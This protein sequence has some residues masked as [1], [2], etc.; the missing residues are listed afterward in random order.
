M[1]TEMDALRLSNGAAI[2]IILGL[3]SGTRAGD[4]EALTFERHVRP[5]LKAYCLDCHGSGTELKGKL[6]LRLARTARKGGKQGPALVPGKPEESLLL[7]RIREG[8]M[9]PGEKRVPPAQVAVIEGW[10]AQGARTLRDEPQSLPPGIDITLEERAFW[11]FQPNRQTGPPS[12]APGDRARVRTPIDVFL[13]DALRRRGSSFA[14]EADRLTLLCRAAFDLTGLPPDDDL[15]EA[16]LA[17]RRPDSYE[18]AI[19]RLLDSPHYGE[20]WARYWLDVA[21][22]ADSD[23]DGNEDTP[24]PYAYRYRDYVV[25][26]FNSDKPLDRFIIEQLAGDELVPRPWANL[27]PEQ[28]ETLAATGYLRMVADPTSSGG[29]DQAMASNQ[30]VADTLKVVGSSLLGLTVGCAQ[31]HDHRY[32]PIPQSDYYRLRAVFEPALDPS[33]WR[34]PSQRLVS[35]YADADRAIAAAVEAEAQKLEK[36]LEPKVARYM[37]EALEKE[38]MKFPVDVRDKLRDAYRTPEPKR[39]GEQRKLLASHPSVNLTEGVLYQYNQAAADDLKKERAKIAAVRARK[40]VEEFVS[41]LDEVPGVLPE[42][43]IFHRGD[44]RQ[45]TR[46]VAPGD[47][48]IAAPPGAPFQIG[49]KDA[50]VPTSGRRLAY[51]R[52][53]VDGRHPLVGRVLVNRIWMHHFGRGLVETPGDLGAL[54]IRPTHPDLL[55]WL[56]SELMRQNWSLKRMHRLIMT[57]T[58]YRLSS[59]RESAG[60]DADDAWYGRFPVRRLDAEVLRDRVL[61]ASGRLDPRLYGRPVPV[62]ED[63]VG[64]VNA[65]NDSPRR[66][67]YVEVRRTRPV[68]LLTAFDAPVMAVNC[69]RRTPST[70][71]IQSLMLMNSDFLLEHAKSMA[72]RLRSEVPVAKG[73]ARPDLDRM[74]GRAWRI[75]YGR[76]ITGEERRWAREFLDNQLAEL[77]RAKTGGDCDLVA[78]ANLCQQLLTSNE[79]LYVD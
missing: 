46:G 24:R 33:H 64:Q 74:I 55:D 66:S 53:L 40:P 67:L 4:A 9:P 77:A 37:A 15:V 26:S 47:L 44:H 14:T 69:D 34:R 72:S 63:S 42:T 30:V 76:A 11:A 21:G 43:R 36:A 35:L 25:R 17:D 73:G 60:A 27:K 19:D 48:T 49:A 56:A 13:L 10:I 61:C 78:L 52:H 50:R 2:V 71:A 45:P 29:Q 20:R 54:G 8:E 3:E 5:I 1:E 39:S 32:D 75:A 62:T 65:A 6:D 57:S 23:G 58:A 28:I 38:M 16:F 22:Y 59:R 31:C 7:D 41:V 51:A 12:V 70:S 79:F 68:S 18:R